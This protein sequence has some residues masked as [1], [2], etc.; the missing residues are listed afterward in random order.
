MNTYFVEHL[1]IGDLKKMEPSGNLA[2]K[3]QSSKVSSP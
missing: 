2:A 3:A 1:Q